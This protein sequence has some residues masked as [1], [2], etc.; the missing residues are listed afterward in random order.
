MLVGLL[1]CGLPACAEPA[2]ALNHDPG[3]AGSVGVRFPSDAGTSPS[4]MGDGVDLGDAPDAGPLEPLLSIAP[5]SSPHP[6][7]DVDGHDWAAIIPLDVTTVGVARVEF[8]VGAVFAG[9][10]DAAPHHFDAVFTTPGAR[11]LVAVG[12]DA[13]G[14]EVAR[15]EVTVEVTPTTDASC[16]AMLDVLGFDWAV[17][18]P[19]TGIDDPV[20]VEPIINGV[21]FR[22]VDN[23]APTA[24]IMD[25]TLG[26]R[27]H[28]LTE[29]IKPLGMDEVIH[30]GIYNYRCI[31]GIPLGDP[32]CVLSK[33]SFGRAI[34]LYGFGLAA[35]DTEYTLLDDWLITTGAT[36]PGAPTGAADTALHTIGCAMWNQGAFQTIL[37]PN[38][39]AA[40]RN[41][42]HVDMGGSFIKDRHGEQ[43]LPGIDPVGGEHVH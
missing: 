33:H 36:C 5:V 20:R 26:P 13:D 17:T 7:D 19:R 43:L 12:L 35:S 15:D 16:H 18:T 14:L 30:I 1:A 31:G 25:C 32:E 34:D 41:H 3:P 9:G 27:L 39:N 4:D 21:S 11:T 22:Y 37:T 29:I 28:Q 23:A 38:Y 42:F 6:M 2:T 10:S 24:M 8:F 40:H